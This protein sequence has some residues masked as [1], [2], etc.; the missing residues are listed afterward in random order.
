MPI[1]GAWDGEHPF[2][3]IH[4]I[5][6]WLDFRLDELRACAEA[7]DVRLSIDE[8]DAAAVRQGAEGVLLRAGL[9]DE[10]SVT[11]LAARTVLVRNY[12][13]VWASGN[14][15]EELEENIRRVP[16]AHSAPYLAEGT[17]FRVRVATFGHKYSPEE[18]KAFV[19]K[20]GPLLPWKG[21]VKM[22]RPDH[23]FC[24]VVDVPQQQQPAADAARKA[25]PEKV[26]IGGASGHRPTQLAGVAAGPPAKYYFGRLVAEGQRSLVGTLDLKKVRRLQRAEAWRWRVGNGG[27]VA[28]AIPPNWRR[29]SCPTDACRRAVRCLGA[30]PHHASPIAAQLHW[31]D[32]P[33][34]GA[35]SADGQPCACALR[36]LRLRSVLRHRRRARNARSA[37]RAAPPHAPPPPARAATRLSCG[38]CE[39]T[40]P[41]GALWRSDYW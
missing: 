16:G 34:R 40:P 10:A 19:D 3:L 17:T 5:H 25:P 31:H 11:R 4:L 37:L 33:R 21:K 1:G 7:T 6:Q 30:V 41:R 36:P 15:W 24:V 39:V 8:D 14:S 35:I 23:T 9:D 18:Q 26:P 32:E 2:Y 28:C 12:Y 27:S 38:P 22:Q 13:E 29:L 20:L